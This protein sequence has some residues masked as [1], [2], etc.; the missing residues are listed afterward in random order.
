MSEFAYEVTDTSL[1]LLE[2]RYEEMYS[3]IIL[4]FWPVRQGYT[5]G[6]VRVRRLAYGVSITVVVVSIT[7]IMSLLLRFGQSSVVELA[8]GGSVTFTPTTAMSGERL[9]AIETVI[10]LGS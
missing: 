1:P 9:W 6:G 8:A 5:S 10:L 2:P 7:Y 4:F 3:F